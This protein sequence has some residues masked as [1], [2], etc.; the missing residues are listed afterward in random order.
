[1]SS[2][3]RLSRKAQ[4]KTRNWAGYLV[5]L[6]GAALLLIFLALALKIV[7][8]STPSL[9][10]ESGRK[11]AAIVD[12]TSRL[13]PNPEF[14]AT[15]QAALTDAGFAVDVYQGKD[16]TIALYKT[17][18]QKGYQLIFFRTHSSN[19]NVDDPQKPGGPVFL[20]TGEKYDKRQYVPEQIADQIRPSQVFY[21]ES[22]V[23]FAIGPEFVR[24]S[25][26][27]RFV[28]TVIV[29]GGCQSMATTDLAQALVERGAA[30]I[31][32]WDE[33]VDLSHNDEA[34]LRLLKALTVE[35]LSVQQAVEA[36]MRDVGPDPIYRSRLLYLPA[37]RGDYVV[38]AVR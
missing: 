17:L 3:K 1:M 37:T 22:A 2:R 6:G 32:G 12:Q 23:F 21:E 27:G 13:Q 10:A 33:W 5:L 36:T 19:V 26:A 31:I 34:I 4:P 11:K 24:R 18:P 8:P 14:L 9:P 15:A 16:V 35:G 30:A 25:M 20:F 38:G 28:D 29:I 7:L